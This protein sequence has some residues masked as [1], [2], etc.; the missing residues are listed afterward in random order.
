MESAGT[1]RST[2]AIFYILLTRSSLLDE[3]TP[4]ADRVVDCVDENELAGFDTSD[5]DDDME[6]GLHDTDEPKPAGALC[7]N[8]RPAC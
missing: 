5:E 7:F 2:C 6:D 1:L 3:V 4:R 8:A